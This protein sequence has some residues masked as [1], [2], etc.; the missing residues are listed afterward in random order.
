MLDEEGIEAGDEAARGKSPL[1]SCVFRPLYRRL[2]IT[3]PSIGNLLSSRAATFSPA[4][5]V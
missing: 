1:L 2:E 4:A 5:F 3:V